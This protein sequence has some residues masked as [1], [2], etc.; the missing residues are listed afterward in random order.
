MIKIYEFKN[1]KFK[2]N[3]MGSQSDWL[4]FVM[5]ARLGEQKFA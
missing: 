1:I 2:R 3:F 4:I 5:I